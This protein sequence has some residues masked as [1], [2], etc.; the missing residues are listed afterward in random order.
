MRIDSWQ[1]STSA[2]CPPA[3]HTLL[4]PSSGRPSRGMAML[5]VQG[6]A[7]ARAGHREAEEARWR[8]RW[9]ALG[10]LEAGNARLTACNRSVSPLHLSS[11]VQGGQEPWG[12][13]ER[14]PRDLRGSPGPPP[15][16]ASHRCV[17]AAGAGLWRLA[18]Q[19]SRPLDARPREQS[20]LLC[21]GGVAHRLTW[22]TG[23]A[24][25]DV[26]PRGRRQLSLS[27]QVGASRSAHS[28]LMFAAVCLL[29]I[30][31]PSCL[32][33]CPA[34]LCLTLLSPVPPAPACAG[35]CAFT[36]AP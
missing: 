18:G 25:P 15:P 10:E 30:R 12:G 6:P 17:W 9:A 32:P 29:A 28:L 20:R 26:P 31:T 19:P 13:T 21:P 23:A 1:A 14:H 5:Q 36:V 3:A 35:G 24:L 11:E 27:V 7:Q 16:A 2:V 8:R 4:V 22:R 33:A 34:P